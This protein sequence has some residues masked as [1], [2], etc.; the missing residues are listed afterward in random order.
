MTMASRKSSQ[1][2]AS[3]QTSAPQ[4]KSSQKDKNRKVLIAAV[5]AAVVIVAIGIYAIFGVGT[6]LQSGTVGTTNGIPVYLSMSAMGIVIGPATNYSTY[7]LFN[8]S[9]PG[10]IT[11]VESI[12]PNAAANVTEG[13]V[14][15][16]ESQNAIANASL[17]FYV[18]KGYNSSKLADSISS[19]LAASFATPPQTSYGNYNGLSYT[20]ENYINSTANYQVLTGW[21]GNYSVFGL[22][23]SNSTFT[24]NAAVLV[25]ASADALPPS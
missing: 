12:T 18:M 10:N 5:V 6:G 1:T 11:I 16:A 2:D 25:S 20:Y 21:S 19:A 7:D 24:A 22:L 14:T 9:A 15:F 8:M 13:W 17:Q 3:Q 23:I 4:P